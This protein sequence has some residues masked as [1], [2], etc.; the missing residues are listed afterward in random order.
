MLVYYII[1]KNVSSVHEVSSFMENAHRE[2]TIQDIV[3]VVEALY[4]CGIDRYVEN[5]KHLVKEAYTQIG[6]SGIMILVYEFIRSH[7]DPGSE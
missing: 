1:T 4:Q 6:I 5:N 3:A 2:H 7:D